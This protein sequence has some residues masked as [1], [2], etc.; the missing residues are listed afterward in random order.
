MSL[1]NDH[2]VGLERG[3]V[4]AMGRRRVIST[5]KMRKIRAIRKNR[6]EKDVRGEDFGSNP[7]S[8]GDLF[9]RSI[10]DFFEMSVATV[11]STDVM[12]R[13]KRKIVKVA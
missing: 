2:I 9:S 3:I 11:I 8:N 6:I 4:L 7:H 10:I 12:N 5:S 13:V 1:V